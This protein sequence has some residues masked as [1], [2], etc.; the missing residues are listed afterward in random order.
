VDDRL[1]ID[2]WPAHESEID[3]AMLPG[4]RHR[5]RIEYYQVGGW[6]ELRAEVRKR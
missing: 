4:G 6:V 1:V 5:L 3:R 2:R